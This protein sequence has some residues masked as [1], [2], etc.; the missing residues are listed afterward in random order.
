MPDQLDRGVGCRQSAKFHI[1]KRQR[2][3]GK[4]AIEEIGTPQQHVPAAGFGAAQLQLCRHLTGQKPQ[5]HRAGVHQH[6]VYGFAQ[7]FTAGLANSDAGVQPVHP[8]AVW[9]AI[10]QKVDNVQIVGKQDFLLFSGCPSTAGRQCQC[11]RDKQKK[12]RHKAETISTGPAHQHQAEAALSNMR[13]PE[14]HP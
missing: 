7:R 14:M 12:T 2:A 4:R 10:Y 6:M 13:S 3:P 1:S 5:S 9:A 8:V 11:Q